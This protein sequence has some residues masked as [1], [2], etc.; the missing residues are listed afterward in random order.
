MKKIKFSKRLITI[1]LLPVAYCLLTIGCS[2]SFLEI[3][4]QGQ[5]TSDNFFLTADQAVQATNAV[6]SYLRRWEV[7]VFS[8]IG[9]TDIRSDD[10]DKGSEPTDA[11]FL[12]DI[13]NFTD[14]AGNVATQTSWGGYYKA[15][16]RANIAIENIAGITMDETLK[17]RLIGESK[18]L[19]AYLYFNLV[20]WYGDIPLVVH[21]LKSDEYNQKRKPTTEIYAQIVQDLKDGI[22]ALP[23]KSQYPSADLGRVTKGTARGLLSEVCLTIGDYAGAE[24]YASDLIA[25]K[26][27]TLYPDYAKIF[28]VEGENCS[29]SIFEVQCAASTIDGTS[30]YN[31]VQ[32]VR[33][34]PDLGWGFNRPS[35]DLVKEFERGDPRRAATV[36][37]EG[38]VLPDGSAIVQHNPLEINARYNKKAFNPLVV[39]NDNGKG[40]GNIRLLRYS[41]IILVYAEA[42]NENG[43]INEAVAAVNQVRARARGANSNVVPDITASSKDA[44]RTAIWHERRVELAM[45][46]HRWFD[47]LRQ[48]R[49]AEVM[50][51]VGKNFI[52]GKHELFPIPQTEIDISAGALTQNPLY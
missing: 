41:D 3:K 26:E 52:K 50:K 48:K 35:D 34:T 16:F 1:C 38:E 13:D 18:V 45:E 31:Q 15:I 40:Q 28:R 17:K 37:Y 25:S 44:V 29:E 47:L 39:A 22:D 42:A 46:Q 5:L 10:A 4:P 14:D 8:Y 12:L 32:G 2:K 36:L 51:A 49:A 43:K 20:R 30:Q 33:G 27:Y 24:K 11:S 21:P 6:Y 19:R 9:M 23:E 7:H